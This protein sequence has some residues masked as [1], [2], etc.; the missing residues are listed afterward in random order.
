MSRVFVAGLGAVS[1]AGWNV[2]AMREALERGE[3]LAAQPLDSRHEKPLL[4][5]LV[6]NPSVRPDF[7]A[8]PRLRRASPITHYSA[9]AALEAAAPFRR[10]CPENARIGLISCLQSGCVN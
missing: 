5:H 2:A 4:A 1:P 3:P 8:H 7:L 6:P 10:A 9:S